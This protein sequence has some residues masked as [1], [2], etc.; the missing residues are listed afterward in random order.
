MFLL[1]DTKDSDAT[2]THNKMQKK[3]IDNNKPLLESNT[4]AYVKAIEFLKNGGEIDK[5]R[6]KYRVSLALEKELLN[7]E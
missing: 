3:S 7:Q 1:D 2:N 4:K 5:I 6:E